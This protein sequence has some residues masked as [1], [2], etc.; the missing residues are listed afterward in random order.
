MHLGVQVGEHSSDI[1]VDIEAEHT[2]AELRVALEGYL[3][4]S[5]PQ[6]YKDGTGEPLAEHSLVAEAGLVSGNV[7]SDRSQHT[8]ATT[9]GTHLVVTQGH[10]VGHSTELTNQPVTVGRDTSNDLVVTDPQISRQQFSVSI[11]TDETI[12][13][14]PSQSATNPVRINGVET[15][16]VRSISGSDTVAAGGTTFA[17]RR[18]IAR[19]APATDRFGA[20]PFNRTPYFRPGETDPDFTP[21][22]LPAAKKAQRFRYLAAISPLFAG[23]G[24]AIFFD[25]RRFLLFAALSPIIAIGNYIDQRYLSGKEHREALERFDSDLERR[26]SEIEVALTDARAQR[27]AQAPDIDELAFR[28]E[29]QSELLWLR[30]RKTSDFLELRVGIGDL[31]SEFDFSIDRKGEL[32]H[33]DRLNKLNATGALLSDV[34]ITLSLPN[35]GA[36][37]VVGDDDPVASLTGSLVVQAAC[38]HS[39]EDLIIIGATQAH[40]DM[41]RWMKWLPHTRSAASPLGGD[42]LAVGVENAESILKALAVVAAE[43][44][45][46]SDNQLDTRWPWILVVL[47]GE[48][49]PDAPVVSQILEHGPTVGISMV[50]MCRNTA[51]VPRQAQAVCKIPTTASEPTVLSYVDTTKPD[52]RL[53]PERI[54]FPLAHQTATDLAALRDASSANAATALPSLVTLLDV[55]GRSAIDP[56]AIAQ[57]WQ[58]PKGYTL[59]APFAM[60]NDGPFE[61][62]LVNDGPHGLIGGTSGSGKSELL[63]SLLTGLVVRN[64]PRHLN[65]LFI[66]YKGGAL[67]KKF[68]SIPHTVGSVT[69]LDALMANRALTSLL[70]EL[71]YRM[72]L[73]D[74]LDM[75]KMLKERPNDAPASLVLVVDEFAALVRELPQFVD[76]VVSIAERGRSLGIHLLLAT[77]RPSG[78]INDNIQQNTDLRIALRMI[79]SSE[80]SNVIGAPDAAGIPKPLQG[81]AIAKKSGRLVSI[82]SAYSE[83][84]Y[85][86][87]EQPDVSITPFVIAGE[88]ADTMQRTLV[89]TGGA[90][91]EGASKGERAAHQLDRVLQA[92]A[93]VGAAP[94]R[95]PWQAPLPEEITLT[96]AISQYDA[97]DSPVFPAVVGVLDDPERQRQLLCQFD[98]HDGPLFAFG[99]AGSGK[100]TMLESVSIA[101]SKRAS[102]QESPL[103]IIVFDFA[104]RALASLKSLPHF[105]LYANGDDLEATTRAIA[106]IEREIKRRRAQAGADEGSVEHPPILLVIDGWDNLDETLRPTTAGSHDLHVWSEKIENLVSQGRQFGVYTVAATN[107]LVRTKLMS[108]I[109]HRLVLRQ[110]G[111]NEYRALGLSSRMA[112]DLTLRPGQAIDP[113]GTLIQI[114]IPDSA[115]PEIEHAATIPPKL[116]LQVAAPLPPVLSLPDDAKNHDHPLLGRVDLSGQSVGFDP[117]LRRLLVVG[118]PRSGKSTVLALLGQQLLDRGHD[119]YVIGAERSPLAD[120]SFNWT[121]SVFGDAGQIAEF[122]S[123][124]SRISDSTCLLFDDL[125]DFDQRDVYNHFDSL[126]GQAQIVLGS[127]VGVRRVSTQNPA[128]THLKNGRANLLLQMTAREINEAIGVRVDLR[129]GLKPTAGRGLLLVDRLPTVLQ[130]FQPSSAVL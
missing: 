107:R 106:L 10:S 57:G 56:D 33:K 53:D 6:L 16:G 43:R 12:T 17:I 90:F 95:S 119:V 113:D 41:H 62:D 4:L 11:D 71:N 7:L 98:L 23:I 128:F 31:P 75:A 52:Q 13:L 58:T 114:A 19:P 94:G 27:F 32:H 59:A 104:S 65:L 127:T 89:F 85:H 54:D 77:Q 82:Q 46:T 88:P 2:V 48:L 80:S 35:V 102:A 5:I 70:A 116:A 108:A 91:T 50:W 110:P 55:L 3:G 18:R 117:A 79:S 111:E 36:L 93:Q 14:T 87:D 30:D 15:H 22:E 68:D 84:P 105:G 51:S 44:A 24:M 118:P 69:N 60:S 72:Q 120:P 39:P 21:I 76:G 28:A 42:H 25:S 124:H 38:L 97:P 67:S 73:F 96:Q 92:I 26:E 130:C 61:L 78:S 34:P 20:T 49:D 125:E 81:R 101:A 126:V 112:K 109:P 122:V 29:S 86:G 1:A 64:S 47:D 40:R 100:S 115:P 63:Q 129:P 103:T 8:A 83:A 99:G 74:G 121:T 45:Q 123:E 9:T 66:D 37:A